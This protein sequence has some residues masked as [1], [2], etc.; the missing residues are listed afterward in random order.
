[1][2]L[3]HLN[4]WRPGHLGGSMVH[5]CRGLSVDQCRVPNA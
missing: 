1:M 3:T 2:R 4:G 5:F